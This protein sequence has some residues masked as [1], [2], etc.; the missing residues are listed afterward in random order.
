MPFCLYIISSFLFPSSSFLFLNFS[1]NTFLFI[2]E[3]P[4]FYTIKTNHLALILPKIKILILPNHS[5]SP[6]A[7]NPPLL[8]AFP[9]IPQSSPSFL[10]LS[11]SSYFLLSFFLYTFPYTFSFPSIVLFFLLSLIFHHQSSNT[12]TLHFWASVS[13]S[14]ILSNHCNT[15]PQ[16]YSFVQTLDDHSSAIT[17]VRFYQGQSTLQ[18]VSCSADRSII[19]RSATMVSK[20]EASLFVVCGEGLKGGVE[21]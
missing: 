13:S 8:L 4:N 3:H 9:S 18:M 10:F 15:H 19:F 7:Q 20:I 12:F 2:L 11:F 21:H 5:Q 14:C 17:S 6:K 1:I 16:D